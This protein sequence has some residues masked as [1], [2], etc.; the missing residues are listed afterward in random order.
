[1]DHANISNP[2]DHEMSIAARGSTAHQG[3]D[4]LPPTISLDEVTIIVRA[5]DGDLDAFDTLITTYQGSIFRLAYRMLNDRTEAEDIVQETFIAAWR[6]L[7]KLSTPQLFRP[8]LYRTA[9]N[10]CLDT[11]RQRQRRPTTVLAPTDLAEHQHDRDDARTAAAPAQSV[12]PAAA[13]EAEAQMRALADLLETVPPESKACWLLREV[14]DFSY[15]EI[16]QM[17]QLPPSTVRGRIARAKR[18]LAEGMESWR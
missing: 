16:A 1:M 6:S 8:W 9:T 3:G 11:L 5:Q 4:E 13:V 10:K 17:M 7:P 12:D 18:L 14:H 15:S 2:G